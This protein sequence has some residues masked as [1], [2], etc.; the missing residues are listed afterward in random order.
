MPS[1]S[2]LA[3]RTDRRPRLDL[4]EAQN[5]ALAAT[6]SPDPRAIDENLRGFVMLLSAHFQGFCR[7][8]HTECV[9]AVTGALP[10][11]FQPLVQALCVADR[12]LDGGNPRYAAL[13]G[14]F[15]RFRFDLTAA[16][17]QDPALPPAVR[18]A[19]AGHITRVDHL[20]A[21]RNY[22]AHHNPTPPVQGGPLTPAAARLWTD[23]C[24]GLASELDRVMYDRIL[25]LTGGPPW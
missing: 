17:T 3:W 16:L 4:I 14:D 20:N 15:E 2:L 1:N 18:A 10:A 5:L 7:D 23:S 22:V 11:A 24:D 6:P 19:N 21:W 8:L 25:A 13:K 9:Q 12:K